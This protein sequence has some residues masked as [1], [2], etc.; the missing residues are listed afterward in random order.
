MQQTGEL[1][2]L[3]AETELAKGQLEVNKIEAGSVNIFVSGWRPFVGWTCGL[4]LVYASFIEPLMRFIAQVGFKYEGQFPII[5]TD[6]TTTILLGMLGL[7]AMRTTE[8]VKGI[9]SKITGK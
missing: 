1:A 8:K 9:K 5:N 4:G 3:T 6:I 2:V 7:G